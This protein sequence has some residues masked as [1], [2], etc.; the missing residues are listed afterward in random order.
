MRIDLQQGSEKWHMIRALLATASVAKTLE[1][2]GKSES[3]LGVGALT[4]AHEKLAFLETG[5][6]DELNVKSLEH[7]N[8]WE[9]FALQHYAR[10]RMRNITT[11]GIIVREGFGGYSPDGLVDGEN[12]GAEFK[13]PSSTK[14]FYEVREGISKPDEQYV[15]QCKFGCMIAELDYIDLM[16]FSPY[17]EEGKNSFTVMIERDLDYE[18]MIKPKLDNFYKYMS[19]KLGQDSWQMLKHLIMKP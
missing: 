13:C 19:T 4:K 9:P 8:T 17:F 6:R 14:V 3:G 12:G 5:Q 10:K 1:V 16:Y 18:K 7:G 15:S 11:T 2:N